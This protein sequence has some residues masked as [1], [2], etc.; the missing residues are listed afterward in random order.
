M[1]SD[2]PSRTTRWRSQA[3][4]A[5]GLIALALSWESAADEARWIENTLPNGQSIILCAIDKQCTDEELETAAAGAIGRIAALYEHIDEMK[6]RTVFIGNSSS[7]N[8]WGL[9]YEYLSGPNCGSED[10]ALA[11]AN[12]RSPCWNVSSVP[13]PDSLIAD[14][15][16][17][18]QW[19]GP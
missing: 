18:L 12:T 16:E 7:G 6:P 2:N 3:N 14:W 5:A 19:F 17:S 13:V 1:K 4:F 11:S 9:E 10:V 15:S 8:F